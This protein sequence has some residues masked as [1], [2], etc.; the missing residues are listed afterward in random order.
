MP[1]CMHA[2]VSPP[3]TRRRGAAGNVRPGTAATHIERAT[4]LYNKEMARKGQHQPRAAKLSSSDVRSPHVHAHTPARP[5]ARSARAVRM[6]APHASAW[7]HA[8]ASGGA[9]PLA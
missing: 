7:T 2:C 5:H 3:P 8:C 9:C 4:M 1:A 6:H